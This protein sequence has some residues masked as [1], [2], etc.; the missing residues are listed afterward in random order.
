[1]EGPQSHLSTAQ[2]FALFRLLETILLQAVDRISSA[3]SVPM[4]EDIPDRLDSNK[5]GGVGGLKVLQ[6]V[7]RCLLGRIQLLCAA[8]PSEDIGMAL[9]ATESDFTVH[10]L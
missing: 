8:R 5:A 1:M 4:D 3:T 7:H 10:S 9:V 2:A 6:R